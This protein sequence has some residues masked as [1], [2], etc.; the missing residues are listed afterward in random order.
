MESSGRMARSFALASFLGSALVGCAAMD[1]G[2]PTRAEAGFDVDESYFYVSLGSQGNWVQNAQFGWVWYPYNRPVNWRPYT[3]GR[4]VLTSYGDWMWVSDEPF[5]WATYHYGRWFMD[6]FYGW[7]WLPGRVWA[8]AWVSWRECDDYVGWAP[9]GPWGYWDNRYNRY[10]DWD[11]W[12]YNGRV[13]RN[14]N[15]YNNHWRDDDDR[16][17]HHGRGWDERPY[18]QA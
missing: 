15:A 3:M 12:G 2:A 16:Y 10:R 4:W 13:Y 5:G 17:D 9:L 18:A 14:N 8:P 7:V 1:L 11:R 6:P